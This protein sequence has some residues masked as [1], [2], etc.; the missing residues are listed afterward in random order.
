M[1]PTYR[2]AFET[3]K[4]RLISAPS[5]VL[6]EVSS[7]EMLTVATYAYAVGIAIV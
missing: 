2:E 4:L 6:L 7:D 5:L 3:L 1:T